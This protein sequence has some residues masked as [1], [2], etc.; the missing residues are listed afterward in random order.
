MIAKKHG[1]EHDPENHKAYV[2]GWIKALKDDPQEIFKAARD[3]ERISEMVYGL[4]KQKEISTVKELQKD[5]EVTAASLKLPKDNGITTEPAMRREFAKVAKEQVLD[6]KAEISR[7]GDVHKIPR[8]DG[9]GIAG[10][11]ELRPD[12][13]GVMMNFETKKTV[14]WEHGKGVLK[15]VE[16]DKRQELYKDKKELPPL[17]RA[18][19]PE[20]T[21]E[22]V[23][24]KTKSIGIGV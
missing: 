13:K 5:K 19:M 10:I 24:A 11:Y 2:K 18:P 7:N 6:C 8:Q 4:A 9:K 15:T 14:Y 16:Q 22:P 12:G 23:K 1:I 20:R 21:N 3:A 17:I